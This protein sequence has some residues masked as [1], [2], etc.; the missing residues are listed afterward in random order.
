[1][2]ILVVKIIGKK[3]AR[4]N[5]IRQPPFPCG[6]GKGEQLANRPLPPD[7]EGVSGRAI[8]SWLISSYSASLSHHFE[9][10][11]YVIIIPGPKH[12]YIKKYIS[13]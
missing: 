6:S 2:K 7:D 10:T 12:E 3:K 4:K 8:S 13:T 11:W 5:K 9:R 1:M